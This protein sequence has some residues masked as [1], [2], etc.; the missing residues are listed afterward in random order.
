MVVGGEGRMP[1]TEDGMMQMLAV[2][3]P[4]TS[5][6]HVLSILSYVDPENPSLLVSSRLIYDPVAVHLGC[7]NKTPQTM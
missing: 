1:Q 7:Y 5:P 2:P 3:H 4:P 6:P